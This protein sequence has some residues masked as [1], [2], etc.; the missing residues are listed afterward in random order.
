MRL[1]EFTLD[2]AKS[3]LPSWAAVEMTLTAFRS[4]REL[5]LRGIILGP[6]TVV[7]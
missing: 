1:E 6:L 5:L 4:R 2:Y 7:M 3:K